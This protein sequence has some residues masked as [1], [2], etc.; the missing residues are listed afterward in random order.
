MNFLFVS[1]ESLAGDL[2][3]RL[4][5]EKHEV[6]VY[7]KEANDQDVYDGFLTRV[8][9]WRPHLDWADL[10]I[11]E[12]EAFGNEAEKLRKQGKLVIGGT[13]Y[14]D[15]LEIDRAFGQKELKRHGVEVLP[16]WK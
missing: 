4:I 5:E 15:R 7:S 3:L 16:T 11:F 1:T 12:E 8:K 14:S 6:R 2:A 13:R 9:T 10:I